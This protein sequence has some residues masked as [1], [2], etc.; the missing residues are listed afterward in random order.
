M[1]NVYT[2]SKNLR[3]AYA[4]KNPKACSKCLGACSICLEKSKSVQHMPGK[5]GFLQALLG[6]S[7][8]DKGLAFGLPLSGES[9]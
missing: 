1:V 6:S 5:I 3:A 2:E 8:P 4:W 7:D 9:F